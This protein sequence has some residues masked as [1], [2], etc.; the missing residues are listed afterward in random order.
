MK[1]VFL[2]AVIPL[3]V[4]V[5]ACGGS[6]TTDPATVVEN[7]ITAKVNGSR[8]GL[9]PLICSPLEATLDAEAMSFSAVDAEISGM[10]CTFDEASST[11]TCAG[12]INALYGS[13]TREFP[14]STYRVVQED[15]A[16]KWCGEGG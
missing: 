2:C 6:A 9:A 5:A 11:V 1:R 3:S 7:Y 12:T 15:G 13:E 16:W 4:I 10:D 14:L 8:E